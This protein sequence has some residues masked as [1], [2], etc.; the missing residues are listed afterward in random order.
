MFKSLYS[1]L[2]AVVLLLFTIIAIVM[3][4]IV[5]YATDLYR[6]EINQKLNMDLAENIVKEKLLI[7]NGKIDRDALE[8]IFHILMVINPS[9]ELYLLDQGGTILEFSAAPGKVKRKSVSLGPVKKLLARQGTVP[10]LGDDPRNPGGKKVFSVSS[11]YQQNKL[12]GYLYVILGGEKYDTIAQKIQNSFILK[13]SSWMIVTALAF[14]GTVGLIIFALLTR[15]L[16]KLVIGIDAFKNG[17]NLSNID[18]PRVRES[19]HQGDEIDNLSLAFKEMAE[20]IEEQIAKL[21]KSDLMRRELVANVSHDLRTPLA[22]LTAYIE[23]MQLKEIDWSPEKRQKYLEVARKHCNRLSSLVDD[24]FELASL[25]ARETKLKLESF[26]I[27][28]LVQDV[29]QNYELPAKN[30]NITLTSNFSQNLTYVMG[31]IGLVQRVLENLIA[32]AFRHTPEGGTIS[33]ILKSADDFMTVQVRDTG[34]GIAQEA[35]PHIFD[36]FY[37]SASNNEN[38]STSLAGLGLGLAIAK[39]IMD[40]HGSGIEVMSEPKTGTCFTF[41]FPIQAMA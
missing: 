2:A 23:T 25:D 1:K 21:Q 31:D 27:A 7:R 28:E 24:L 16:R 32:N 26:S 3:V 39:R 9:I 35:L 18:L 6:Q 41:R 36:R 19:V 8:Y 40:L 10:Q 33:I 12:E 11:I 22:T 34:V 20:R 14:A 13:M 29:V 15:R 17:D 4:T 38:T 30:R 5:I 37:K